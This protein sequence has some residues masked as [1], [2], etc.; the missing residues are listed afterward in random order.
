M[1]PAM[2][3]SYPLRTSSASSC[4]D[5][6]PPHSSSW[7]RVGPAAAKPT[8]YPFRG[9]SGKDSAPRFDGN[10]VDRA[11]SVELLQGCPLTRDTPEEE[12]LSRGIQET[13]AAQRVP[14]ELFA[15]NTHQQHLELT[16]AVELCRA[17]RRTSGT[18][19]AEAR[20]DGL[21]PQGRHDPEL[22][23][24]FTQPRTILLDVLD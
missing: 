14:Q 15:A 4:A 5:M 22:V 23:H 21:L 3:A 12:S 8:A 6:T 1:S 16:Q 13:E 24:Q 20:R 19:P 18:E 17:D 11:P 7:V 10:P 2:K 9:Q